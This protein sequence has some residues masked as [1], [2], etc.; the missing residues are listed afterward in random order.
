MVPTKPRQ[1]L[2]DIASLGQKKQ[3]AASC[4]NEPMR[5]FRSFPK[6][7]RIPTGRHGAVVI[8]SK[9]ARHPCGNVATPKSERDLS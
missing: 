7:L 2:P 4:G 5:R 8:K 1:G 3:P 6:V 9:V